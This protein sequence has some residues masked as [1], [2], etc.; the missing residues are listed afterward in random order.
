MTDEFYCSTIVQP[1][2]QMAEAAVS[3]LI[4]PHQESA[5]ALLA[6]PVHFEAHGTTREAADGQ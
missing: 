4:G 6:L 3:L 2:S 1:T 5:P